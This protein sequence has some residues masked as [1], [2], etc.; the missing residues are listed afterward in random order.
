MLAPLA[1]TYLYTAFLKRPRQRWDAPANW[2]E[3]KRRR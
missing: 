1:E 2:T 3:D